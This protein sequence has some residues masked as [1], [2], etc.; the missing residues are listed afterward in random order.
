MFD[1][2]G[3][4]CPGVDIALNF[5]TF[6]KPNA[7]APILDYSKQGG[8]KIAGG[9][10]AAA[11][12]GLSCSAV[13]VVG[14][15]SN[16]LFSMDDFK[17]HGIDTRGMILR[18]GHTTPFAI[19]LSD[20][21]TG[22]RSIAWHRGSAPRLKENELPTDIISNTRILFLSEGDSVSLKA[23]QTAKSKGA[24]IAADPDYHS[25]I[26]SELIGITDIFIGSEQAYSCLFPGGDVMENCRDLCH[27]GPEIVIFTFGAGGSVG[28]TKKEGFFQIPAFS[29]ETI[30]SVGAGDTFHGAFLKGS[31]EGWSVQKSALFASAA[32]A[33]KC[34]RVGSRA[35]M[36]DLDAV[37]GFMETGKID[38]TEIDPRVEFYKGLV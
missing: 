5:K 33:I 29:V 26:S 23:A 35:G 2:V 1:V 31:L 25:G 11:R 10:V 22:G 13:G 16:G 21:E 36:P 19:I 20:R 14:D 32:A 3:M 8:E 24:K 7:H 6:P 27:N 17:R 28:Y 12:L 15:D 9:L 18:N 34:T 37:K 4:V 38:Y 30:D